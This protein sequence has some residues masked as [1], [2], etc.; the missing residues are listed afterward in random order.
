MCTPS[1]RKGV[2]VCTRKIKTKTNKKID[3]TGFLFISLRLFFF[4]WFVFFFRRLAFLM[5]AL[6]L[7]IFQTPM[8]KDLVFIV[9]ID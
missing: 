9:F 1:N 4:F 7:D 5:F 3:L 2:V 6:F 8:W